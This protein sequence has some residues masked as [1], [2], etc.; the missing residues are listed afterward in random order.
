MDRSLLAA[1]S[2]ALTA[3]VVALVVWPSPPGAPPVE[4][5][6]SARARSITVHVSGAVMLPGLVT[7]PADSRVADAIVAAG[8]ATSE[9]ELGSLN[10]AASLG[11]GSHL[12]VPSWGG[13]VAL[14]GDGRVRVNSASASDLEDLPGVGPVLAQ[15]IV[16]HREANGPFQTV[17]GLLDV[18][19]IG[20]AKL[21]AIRDVVL[22]P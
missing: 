18:P 14:V 10:L 6:S 21:A 22:V 13:D 9:A 11:D 5:V 7:L 4:I 12:V 16:A 8:G 1:G 17:E 19:G 15:R 3:V 2:I 20:E